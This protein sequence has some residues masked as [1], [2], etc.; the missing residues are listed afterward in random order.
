MYGKTVMI[1]KENNILKV[2]TFEDVQNDFADR[3]M[4]FFSR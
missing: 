4:F 3:Q 1:P 2:A